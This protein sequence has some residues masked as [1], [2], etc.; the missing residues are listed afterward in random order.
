MSTN[1]QDNVAV[2]IDSQSESLPKLAAFW[3][4]YRWFK[5]LRRNKIGQNLDQ[6]RVLMPRKGRAAFACE[7]KLSLG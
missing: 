3:A 5:T 2:N 1:E 7:Q 4:K 6:I